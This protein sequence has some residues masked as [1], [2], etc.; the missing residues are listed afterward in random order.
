MSAAKWILGSLGFVLYG[1]IGAIVGV[2]I[3]SAFDKQ[4]SLP[5]GDA[6]TNNSKTSSSYHSKN[7]ATAGDIKVSI[8]VLIASVMKA[9]GHVKRSELD[10]VKQFLLKNYGEESGKE[11]LQMLK[12]L[13]ES[14]IEPSTVS[15]Q[16]RDNVN[17]STRLTIL[18]FLLDNKNLILYFFSISC[19]YET[20]NFFILS[21]I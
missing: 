19:L 20:G 6:P 14:N 3:A 16:I 8:L 13:L 9:D 10:V 11:A 2:L 4:K 17:Y 21:S 18:H 7:R 12:K 15:E 5:S 1:P